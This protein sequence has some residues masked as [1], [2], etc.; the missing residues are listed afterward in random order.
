MAAAELHIV[1]DAGHS[2]SEPGIVDALIRAT[3][4]IGKR[5]ETQNDLHFYLNCQ[6]DDST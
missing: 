6:A 5:L 2:A 4:E 1:R 3:E